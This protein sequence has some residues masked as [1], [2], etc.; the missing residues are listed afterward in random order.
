M[1]ALQPVTAGVKPIVPKSMTPQEW[2]SAATVLVAVYGAALST[3]NLIAARRDH[4][5]TVRVFLKRGLAAPGHEPEPVFILEAVN[6]GQRSVTLTSCGLLLP[7][8]KTFLI[9]RPP[10]S[11]TF[12]HEL[13]D[14]KSCTILFPLR[15][16]VRALQQEGFN[17]QVSV[18]AVFTDALGKDHLSKRVKGSVSD[19]AKAAH[20][21]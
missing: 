13:T 15:D 12:P 8:R 10:G 5:R 11:A 16:V 3:Y 14:G 21:V 6:P 18:R 20:A 17:R 7:N 19:W 2:A 1:L 4:H 9:P